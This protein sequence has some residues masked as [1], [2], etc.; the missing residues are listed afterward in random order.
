M[1]LGLSLFG[2]GPEWAKVELLFDRARHI[3]GQCPISRSEFAFAMN[4]AK[5]EIDKGVKARA[6]QP[7]IA[8]LLRNQGALLQ[9]RLEGA[10][11][12]CDRTISPPAPPPINPAL[13]QAGILP[14]E[15]Q[16]PKTIVGFTLPLWQWI[17][18][19][20]ALLYFARKGQE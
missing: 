17:A 10:T 14:V 7:N 2:V 12:A 16:A 6:I 13:T 11:V 19:G 15:W 1:A 20:A 3:L 18:I 9:G 4:E 5:L 8:E